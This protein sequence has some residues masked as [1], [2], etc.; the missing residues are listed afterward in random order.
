MVFIIS[1]VNG[2]IAG[3]TAIILAGWDHGKVNR[4]SWL[5]ILKKQT[6]LLLYLQ[7][8]CMPSM[9]DTAGYERRVYV[10]VDL[11]YRRSISGSLW[12][13]VAMILMNS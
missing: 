2:T 10:N 3:S 7:E 5:D 11:R 1:N 12:L 9:A 6:I 13:N 8:N 4:D